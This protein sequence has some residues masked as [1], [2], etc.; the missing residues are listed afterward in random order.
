MSLYGLFWLPWFDTTIVTLR[1]LQC[2]FCLYFIGYFGINLYHMAEKGQNRKKLCLLVIGIIFFV[3]SVGFW[4]VISTF[5]LPAYV[6]WSPAES[7]TLNQRCLCNWLGLDWH[8]LLHYISALICLF[9]FLIVR[10]MDT[11]FDHRNDAVKRIN[12][13]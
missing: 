1:I 4:F 6:P 9:Y 5:L 13:F 10:Q 12:K 3:I 7:R 2:D 11:C 8:D